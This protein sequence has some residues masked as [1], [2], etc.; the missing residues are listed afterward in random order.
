[1]TPTMQCPFVKARLAECYCSQMNSK[2]VPEIVRY[3]MRDFE[4]CALYHRLLKERSETLPLYA[5]R[6][7]V[8]PGNNKDLESTTIDDRIEE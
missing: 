4:R 8:L 5:F 1:M 7:G 2:Y 3:C 6:N